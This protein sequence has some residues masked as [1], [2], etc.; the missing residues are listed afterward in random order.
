MKN[1]L[2]T[3]GCS[4]TEGYGCYDFNLLDSELNKLYQEFKLNKD[5]T[6]TFSQIFRENYQIQ[7]KYNYFVDLN[8]DR[9]HER[10][11]PVKLAKLLKFDKVINFGVGSGSNA[12][13]VKRFFE[14]D[15]YQNHKFKNSKVFLVWMLTEPT[16]T[17][18]YI[19]NQLR[20]MMGPA[21]KIW[22]SYF[23]EISKDNRDPLDD[24]ILELVFYYKIIENICKSNGWNFLCING[25]S[26]DSLKIDSMLREKNLDFL[27]FG[28]Y[29]LEFRENRSDFCG[30]MNEN[31]YD[32]FSHKIYQYIIS[33][34][35]Y[36]NIIGT[37]EGN[38]E[39][40]WL[41]L[42]LYSKPKDI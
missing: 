33:K 40:D 34:P 37:N 18:L 36:S 31:G 11:W 4:H 38:I 25:P 19:G 29:E 28:Y 6:K 42:W 41:G 14:F 30:H 22:D 35:E 20:D 13:Q 2:I 27:P 5:S 23:R 12:G 1:I 24:S 15:F 39:N 3:L 21:D 8:R 26:S 7:K 10:G 17:A 9:F 16:R 32:L